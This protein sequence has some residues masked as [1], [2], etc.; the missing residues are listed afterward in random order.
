MGLKTTYYLRSLAATQVET[1]T[2]DAKK[3]GYTQKRE[4][5][6][7]AAA[8]T[9]PAPAQAQAQMPAEP[10]QPA[11]PLMGGG[12]SATPAEDEPK[13]CRIDDPDCEACQ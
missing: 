2:L 10:S 3:F 6:A 1:S 13:L 8:A 5:A 11:S 7:V 9:G 12:A 4:Y